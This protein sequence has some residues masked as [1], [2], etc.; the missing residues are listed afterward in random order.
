MQGKLNLANVCL[1]P[2]PGISVLCSIKNSPCA[3]SMH[4][5]IV[6]MRKS[7]EFLDVVHFLGNFYKMDPWIK[8]TIEELDPL[9]AHVKNRRSTK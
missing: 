6:L 3:N 9:M 1:V 7:K 5:V 4:Y 2:L 8:G